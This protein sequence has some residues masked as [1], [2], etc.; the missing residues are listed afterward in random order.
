[1][2]GHVEKRCSCPPQRDANGRK[3]TCRKKHG[4]W[5]YMFDAPR[6]NPQKR[7]LVT[8]GGF[9]TEAEAQQA[10]R[11]ALAQVDTGTYIEDTRTTVAQ[12]LR[13]WMARKS[14]TGQLRPTTQRSYRQHID[15]YLIPHLGH[16][17][18]VEL[19]TAHVDRLYAALRQPDEHGKRRSPTTIR[20]VHATLMSA[21]NA[22]VKR[23]LI[24]HNP[25]AHAD[26]EPATR[27]KV[28]PWEPAELGA[29]LDHAAKHRLG[30]L[31]EVLAFTGLRR[32]EALGLRWFD[33]DL[34]PFSA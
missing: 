9:R 28:R 18:L 27:Q 11:Q 7:N 30:T 12:F 1:M 32:G 29:F 13:E 33:V 34:D 6:T 15:G 20:R 31:Y 26:L 8:K 10:L 16:L 25:A 24:P 19:R 22:A 23:K 5:R 3:I 17:T 4:S 2:T 21:L 14:D